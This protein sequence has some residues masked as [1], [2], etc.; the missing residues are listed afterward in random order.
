MA[1]ALQRLRA[2]KPI[3]SDKPLTEANGRRQG[4]G[5]KVLK[6]TEKTPPHPSAKTAN[7]YCV[8]SDFHFLFDGRLRRTQADNRCWCGFSPVVTLH[9]FSIYIS[10]AGDKRAQTAELCS[11]FL[12]RCRQS[13]ETGDQPVIGGGR[14]SH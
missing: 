2:A 7:S 3:A 1:R 8:R 5:E 13:F 4:P 14:L 11:R 9:S 6:A 12:R 10:D